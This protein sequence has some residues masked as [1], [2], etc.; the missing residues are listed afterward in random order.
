VLCAS[1]AGQETADDAEILHRAIQEERILVTMDE[2]FGDWA[3]LPL[4]KHPGVIRLKVHP[5]TTANI[6]R[7]LSPFLK[8]HRSEDLADHLVILSPQAERWIRTSE[9]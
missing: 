6:A 7:M 2:H 5:T 3:I 8:A 1:E 9:G 4:D